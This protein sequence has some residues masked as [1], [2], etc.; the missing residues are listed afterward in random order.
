M[1]NGV[2]VVLFIILAIVILPATAGDDRPSSTLKDFFDAYHRQSVAG[3]PGA[4]DLVPFLASLSPGLV[5]LLKAA[6][7]AEREAYERNPRHPFV[8]GDLW[9]SLFEG[10]KREE[11]CACR[12]EAGKMLCDIQFLYPDQKVD[13]QWMDT[14]V[15]VQ[16]PDGWKIDDVIWRGDWEFMHKGSL[17]ALLSKIVNR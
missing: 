14:F 2:A 4:A 9:V 10:A 5:D 8:E 1:K 17:R 12:Q 6:E 15:L 13:I 11:I 3:I 16:A 7:R